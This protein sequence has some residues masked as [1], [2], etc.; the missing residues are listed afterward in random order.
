MGDCDFCDTTNVLVINPK[1]LSDYFQMI[2]N[3]YE[4][5]DSGK[6]LVEWMK[7][8]GIFSVI[9]KWILLILKNY[10]PRYWMTAI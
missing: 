9:R 6:T 3:V 2:A 4:A 1:E 5:D 7:M 10:S 8:I